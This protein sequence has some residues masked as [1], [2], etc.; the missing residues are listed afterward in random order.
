MATRLK[1]TLTVC[2]KRL[3]EGARLMIGVPDYD[4][5]VAHMREAHPGQPVMTYAEFFRERQSAR[6]GE[7]STRGFRCC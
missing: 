2:R 5:Y 7:G 6:Y 1:D 4:T 3:R